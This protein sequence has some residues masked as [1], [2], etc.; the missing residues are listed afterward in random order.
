MTEVQT[1]FSVIR[2]E[3]EFSRKTLPESRSPIVRQDADLETLFH[4]ALQN[5]EASFDRD[6]FLYK[7]TEY[8]NT[9]PKQR[10]DDQELKKYLKTVRKACLILRSAQHFFSDGQ[11][12][13]DN[14]LSS[15][16]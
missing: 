1:R 14:K 15:E 2:E 16:G 13:P 3:R 10:L 6:F 12:L 4:L 5:W 7:L 11:F 8:I 9:K